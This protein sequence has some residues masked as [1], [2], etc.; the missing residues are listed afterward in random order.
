[1][2]AIVDVVGLGVVRETVAG[3]ERDSGEMS[4]VMEGSR[5]C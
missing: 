1:M 5:S 4:R 2:D 3:R